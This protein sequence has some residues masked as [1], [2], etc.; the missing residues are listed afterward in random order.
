MR[1][2]HRETMKT[3]KP[4]S[5]TETVCGLRK[6]IEEA[7]VKE[8]A[9]RTQEAKAHWASVRVSA[10]LELNHPLFTGRPVQGFPDP[11]KREEWPNSMHHYFDEIERFGYPNS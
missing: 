10:L 4:L 8:A 2:G 9:A 11:T 5:L 3:S 1:F 6:T 7:T